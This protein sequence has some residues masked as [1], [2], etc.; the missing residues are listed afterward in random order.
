MQRYQG[1]LHVAVA[2]V[3][4][5]TSACGG[6]ESSTTSD[7]LPAG[8][9]TA[10]ALTIKQTAC[11]GTAI[12]AATSFEVTETAGVLTGTVK[13]FSSRCQKDSC[14]YATEDGATTRVLIQPCDLHPTSVPKCTCQGDVTFTLP[15]RT[16]RTTVEVYRREDFYGTTTA[17]Q[18]MLISSRPVGAPALHWYKTCGDV[19]CSVGGGMNAADGGVTACAME[20][21]GDACTVSGSSCDP[22][23]GCNVRLLCTDKD[24]RVQPGGCPISRREAKRDISYLDDAAIN[25]LSIRLRAV[26]L[27]RYRYKDAPD[28][29]RLGFMIDDT[30][31]SMAV[32]EARD[33]IDLYSYLSWTVAAL[34][35]EMKR[36]DAQ[37][38][39][40][41]GLRR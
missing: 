35:G 5:L 15:A 40:I 38:K 41:A 34:Q 8:W 12:P 20:K 17:P 2:V 10:K 3:V 13:N 7:T 29:D 37:E 24:P 9:T 22:Q 6:G 25:D 39:E 33:Q 14:A 4:A 31:G 18:P 28:R 21:Q 16:A 11:S 32:D 27:A 19:V 1:I 23:E 26:R 36:V 30:K